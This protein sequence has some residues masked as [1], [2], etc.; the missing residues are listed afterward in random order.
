ML[1]LE[2][3]VGRRPRGFRAPGYTITDQVFDVLAE[4]VGLVEVLKV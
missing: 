3:A 2:G 1:G 4:L